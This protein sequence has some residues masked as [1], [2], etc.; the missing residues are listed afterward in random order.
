[1]INDNENNV[2][3]KVLIELENF[4]CTFFYDYWERKYIHFLGKFQCQPLIINHLQLT[5]IF[6]HPSQRHLLPKVCS[7]QCVV[8]ILYSSRLILNCIFRDAKHCVSAVAV[9]PLLSNTTKILLT[10]FHSSL[11]I[12]HTNS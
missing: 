9:P 3:K 10:T 7:Q 6:H 8:F 4:F 5:I 11:H 2:A 1:M 12:Y